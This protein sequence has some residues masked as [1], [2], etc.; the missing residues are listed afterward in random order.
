MMPDGFIFLS[1]VYSS[2]TLSK[3]HPFGVHPCVILTNTWS[4]NHHDNQDTQHFHLPKK[5]P[6]V[7]FA[8][9]FL[10][11]PLLCPSVF[12]F[13][14]TLHDGVEIIRSGA[15]GVWLLTQHNHLEVIYVGLS[16][17]ICSF[18]LSSSSTLYTYVLVYPFTS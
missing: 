2:V 10:P 1:W 11:L 4:S 17:R 6:R 7:P 14:R 15:L 8:V 5:V 18:L 3:T 13:S 9:S 16:V 12:A